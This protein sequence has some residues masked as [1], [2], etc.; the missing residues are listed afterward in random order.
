MMPSPAVRVGIVGAGVSATT[1]HAPFLVSNPSFKLTRFLRTSG[2]TPVAGFEKLQV[3]TD[4]Q[5]FLSDIDL[6]VITTPTYTH[7]SIA[8]AC[9]QAGKHVILEKPMCTTFAEATQ[10]CTLARQH[11]LLLAVYHNRRWDGDFRTVSALVK[12][13]K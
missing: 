11:N 13:G 4:M 9:L 3:E 5:Q 12:S 1:F 10:L 7:A 6:V 2:R 8:K